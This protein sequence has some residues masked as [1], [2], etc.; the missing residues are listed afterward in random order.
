ML[1]RQLK[2]YMFQL[3]FAGWTNYTA[4]NI[5]EHDYI[6]LQSAPVTFYGMA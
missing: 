3:L 1:R 6:I 4:M 2:T 5:N